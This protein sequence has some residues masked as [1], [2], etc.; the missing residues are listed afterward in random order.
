V[1]QAF[2]DDPPAIFLAWGKR[3]R[4]ISRRF[5][6]PPADANRDILLT[7]PLWKPRRD[8]RFANHN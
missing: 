7:L 6:V 8:V 5:D 4:A 3:A 1:Q 2:Q